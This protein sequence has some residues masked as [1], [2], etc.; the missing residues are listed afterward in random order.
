MSPP[1]PASGEYRQALLEL[2]TARAALILFYGG[3]FF[4]AA[5][6]KQPIEAAFCFLGIILTGVGIGRCIRRVWPG[7]GAAP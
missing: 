1:E 6:L 2:L 7:G 4:L 3:F 5:I